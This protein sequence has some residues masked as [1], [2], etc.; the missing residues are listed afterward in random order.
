MKP[1]SAWGELAIFHHL[2]PL[3]QKVC[4]IWVLQFYNDVTAGIGETQDQGGHQKTVVHI[5][6]L[7]LMFC[8]H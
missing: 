8:N 4:S 1:S 2:P 6:I 3:D 7:C 5:Y